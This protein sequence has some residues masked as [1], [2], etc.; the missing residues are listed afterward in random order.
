MMASSDDKTRLLPRDSIWVL[1]AA[2]QNLGD[3]I[4]TPKQVMTFGRKTECDVVIPSQYI[5][6][7][8]AEVF[9]KDDQLFIRDLDSTLGTLVNDQPVK[10]ASVQEGDEIRMDKAV[11]VVKRMGPAK[12]DSA[13]AEDK[14]K[15]VMRSV[16]DM[17][18]AMDKAVED[19]KQKQARAGKKSEKTPEENRHET[20]SA[21]PEPSPRKKESAPTPQVEPPAVD[22]GGSDERNS[23]WWDP[24]GSGPMGTRI[25]KPIDAGKVIGGEIK[26]VP[27]ADGPM[28]LGCSPSISELRIK[29]RPGKLVVGKKADVDIRLEDEFVSDVHAQIIG[30]GE[31]WKVVNVLSA[32]GTFVNGKKVQS[33]YLKSGDVIRFGGL[34]V[35]FVNGT[36]RRKVAPQ[37]PG[38]NRKRLVVGAVTV[39]LL[40]LVI[41]I[42]IGITGGR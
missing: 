2:D 7:R 6:R 10:L 11:F 34:E 26:P 14:D 24:K 39:L 41:A 22:S 18:A 28:L 5:S 16:E 27:D 20:E 32:N 21:V 30:E 40:V 13:S 38:N 37:V 3:I 29:L 42:V 31:R 35:Q 4:V 36:R 15:T 33:A 8:H 19:A 12:D 1:S 23:N 25:L 17:K 9:V